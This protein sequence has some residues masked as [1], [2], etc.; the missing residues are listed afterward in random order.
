MAQQK[1]VVVERADLPIQCPRAPVERDRLVHVPLACSLALDAGQR[2]VVCPAQFVTQRVTN[3]EG[4][5]EQPHMAQ[6]RSVEATAELSRQPLGQPRQEPRS[7]RGTL[8]TALLE[9]DD[10]LADL[11]ASVYLHCIHGS[12]RLLPT[13]LDQSAQR[14]QQR[15]Q[16]RVTRGLGIR[17]VT[18]R[19][20]DVDGS[21]M[22]LAAGHGRI[23]VD[24]V[25][26]VI[27]VTGAQLAVYAN[28]T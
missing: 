7:E 20:I 3:R 25:S 22:E 13:L 2:A 8:G 28:R 12:Q 4:P 10:V 6:V 26:G 16:R 24:S 27:A 19:V 17:V 1:P 23:A 18:W 14:G 9:L 15:H 5:V 21:R 11:P